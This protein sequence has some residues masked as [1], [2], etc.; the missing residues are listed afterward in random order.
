M[1]STSTGLSLLSFFDRWTLEKGK[2]YFKRG[3]VVSIALEEREVSGIVRGGCNYQVTVKYRG[4]SITSAL[5]SC[6][7]RKDCKHAAALIFAFQSSLDSVKHL[8]KDES[9]P[10]LML[11]SVP[12]IPM[13]D[14]NLKKATPASASLSDSIAKIT[15]GDRVPALPQV[16]AVKSFSQLSSNVDSIS[17]RSAPLEVVNSFRCIQS[18]LAASKSE[19]NQFKRSERTFVAYILQANSEN[20]KPVIEI[21]TVTVQ[22]NGKLSAGRKTELDELRRS[23]VSSSISQSDLDVAKLWRAVS[24][25][26]ED[27]YHYYNRHDHIDCDP[28]LFAT[29]LTRILKTNRCFFESTN[30]PPLSLGQ[31]IDGKLSWVEI[32]K[33]QFALRVCPAVETPRL[34]VFNGPRLGT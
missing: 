23:G 11:K 29:L 25:S 9:P 6:P 21:K 26:S 4:A 24:Q 28:E 14:S 12:V 10:A 19:H 32:P 15:S 17:S 33:M 13:S 5:C 7:M 8:Q 22:K 30:N 2:D 16:S 3:R 31:Q 20:L 27:R 1:Q 18:A 34:C